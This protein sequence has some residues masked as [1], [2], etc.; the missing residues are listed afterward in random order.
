MR[1]LPDRAVPFR[2]PDIDRYN[3]RM[4]RIAAWDRPIEGRRRRIAAWLNMIFVDHGVFRLFYLN[5]HS[6]DGRLFRAA[7]PWPHQI[8]RFA[9]EGGRSLVYLRGGKEH[10]SWPLEREAAEAHGLEIAEFLARS[11]GAPERDSLLK[12][13]DLFA[14]LQYPALI[15][16]KSGADRA[17]FVAALYVVTHLKRPADEALRQLHWRFGHFRWSKT[18]ILDRFFETYRDEGERRGIAFDDWVRDHYDP[19]RLER[20]FRPGFWSNV[21]VDR[22]LRRE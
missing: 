15:H 6:V 9:R 22:L 10:G 20:E 17:G 11:R 7:Q 13:R 1:L 8:A 21:L 19:E 4:A 5:R 12:A 3:A 16:C 14:S 2:R 18:G